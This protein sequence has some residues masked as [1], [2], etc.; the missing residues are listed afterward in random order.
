MTTP[1][2]PG[3]TWRKSSFSDANGEGACVEVAFP[4]ATVAIRDSKNTTGPILT[5]NA[6]AWSTFLAVATKTHHP[7]T[8]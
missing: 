7:S 6:A 5:V 3:L 1:L 2:S 4:G 8:A